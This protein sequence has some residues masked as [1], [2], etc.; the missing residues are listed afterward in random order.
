MVLAVVRNVK[1]NSDQ[2]S[3]TRVVIF[4]EKII[5][6]NKEQTEILIH[7][8]RN[9]PDSWNGKHLEFVSSHSEDTKKLGIPF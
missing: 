4:H 9:L 3:V 6:G 7:S 8:V 2:E 1:P 5:L